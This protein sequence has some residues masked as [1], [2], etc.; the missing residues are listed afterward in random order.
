MKS[1]DETKFRTLDA[2]HEQINKAEIIPD[3]PDTIPQKVNRT[4]ELLKEN[5]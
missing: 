2:P 5:Q 4:I 1:I 3:A